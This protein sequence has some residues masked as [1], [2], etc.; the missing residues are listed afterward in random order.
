MENERAEGKSRGPGTG[1]AQPVR[2]GGHGL[3]RGGQGVWELQPRGLGQIN[4]F[5]RAR[6][7]AS[8]RLW[9]PSLVRTWRA[10]PANEGIRQIVA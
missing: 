10:F 7:T 5:L 3:G 9:T 8:S 6:V 2:A 1:G 4:P